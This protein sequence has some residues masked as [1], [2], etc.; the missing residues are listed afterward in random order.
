MADYTKN[1]SISFNLLGGG[2][3]T[4]Y[5]EATWGTDVWGEGSQGLEQIVTKG[6]ANSTTWGSSVGFFFV[7][8]LSDS[9][10]LSSDATVVELKSGDY[11]YVFPGGGTDI[12]NAIDTDYTTESLDEASFTT[13]SFTTTTWS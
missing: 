1:I 12:N 13:A 8:T 2:E 4:K 9:F 10:S 11:N 3:A 5:G 6:I 7:I